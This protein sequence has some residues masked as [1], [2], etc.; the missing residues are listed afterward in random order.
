MFRNAAPAEVVPQ[1]SPQPDPADL[2]P[3]SILELD[4]ARPSVG[5]WSHY[6]AEC[7]IQVTSDDLGRPA[8]ARV[9]AR[10][11]FEQKRA[12]EQRAREMA[13]ANEQQAILRDQQ[14]RSQLHP[15]IPWHQIPDGVSPVLAMTAAAKAERPR[16]RSM[17]EDSLDGGGTTMH[18][19]E[20]Q[21]AFEDE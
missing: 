11:L 19:L 3:L 9:D 2:I 13:E 7:G 16:R 10:R 17:L 15:G 4:L 6:L 18:I 8:I 12:A 20:P 21:P 14:W 5:G 1:E